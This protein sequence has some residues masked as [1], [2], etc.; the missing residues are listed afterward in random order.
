MCNCNADTEHK[1]FVTF[2]PL[3]G[4]FG[5]YAYLDIT[6]PL[7]EPT[8]SLLHDA[9]Y[10]YFFLIFKTQPL[11]KDQQK[12]LTIQLGEWYD[13][14][15]AIDIRTTNE[16]PAF[17][18][19]HADGIYHTPPCR[20]SIFHMAVAAPENGTTQFLNNVKAVELMNDSLR[21]RFNNKMV[22]HGTVGSL[23]Q[24]VAE[25][26]SYETQLPLIYHNKCCDL[27]SLHYNLNVWKSLEGETQETSD[28]IKSLLTQYL[29]SISSP[30]Q[31]GVFFEYHWDQGDTIILNSQIVAHRSGP[32]KVS[33]RCIQRTLAF[34]PL[35]Y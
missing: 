26:L 35:P 22:V 23:V 27:V 11:S 10:R 32:G 17:N 13:P 34:G 19:W 30:S 3:E 6:Q 2:K 4:D 5:A 7:D 29:E 33:K 28:E 1:I 21:S 15:S 16:V 18:Y 8:V 31:T 12:N 14:F 20:Y 9:L 25:P 24:I